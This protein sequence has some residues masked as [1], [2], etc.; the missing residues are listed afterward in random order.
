MQFVKANEVDFNCSTNTRYNRGQVGRK[1][2]G[3]LYALRGFRADTGDSVWRE[4]SVDS[5]KPK[6]KVL[7]TRP[8]DTFNPYNVMTARAKSRRQMESTPN[9]PLNYVM[10][11]NAA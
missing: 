5:V 10:G 9:A 4:I 2:N 7:E 3:K 1:E 6:G 8:A 11:R